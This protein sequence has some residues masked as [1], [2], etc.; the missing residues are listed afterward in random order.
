VAFAS[1]FTGDTD[2]SESL[3]RNKVAHHVTLS[4]F[5][6]TGN[7]FVQHVTLIPSLTPPPPGSQS[8]R[9]LIS[10]EKRPASLQ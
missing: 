4:P 10:K 8:K 1:A 2:V 5:F 7:K 3:A 6:L 9:G